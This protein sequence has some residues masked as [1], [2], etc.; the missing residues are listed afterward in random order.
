MRFSR[1]WL[2]ASILALCVALGLGTAHA[3]GVADTMAH[4]T[5]DDFTETL[6]GIKEIAGS[7]DPRAETI[8]RA[9]QDGQLQFSAQRKTVY[10]KDSTGKLTDPATGE[11][12]A[13]ETPADTDTVRINNRLRGALDAALGGLTLLAKSPV[14]R[15]DAAQAVFKSRQAS[16]LPTLDTAIAKEPD[17]RVKRAM[18]EARAAIVLSGTASDE[19]KLAAVDIIRQRRFILLEVVVAIFV[20][21]ETLIFVAQLLLSRR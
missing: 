17:L 14:T 12:V 10:I 2:V 20:V 8:L 16:A 19:D 6:A 4:F 5:A 21:V 18:Q 7:G 13:G 1:A 3:T 15:Y 11:P 9:L